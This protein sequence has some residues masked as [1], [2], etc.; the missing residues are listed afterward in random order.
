MARPHHG[1]KSCCAVDES[2]REPAFSRARERGFTPALANVG[3]HGVQR[4]SIAVFA[5]V[6]VPRSKVT[7]ARLAT[8]V[9]SSFPFG[10]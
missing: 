8:P 10:P 7:V 6:T 9:S 5:A 2:T 3:P 4:F 1:N